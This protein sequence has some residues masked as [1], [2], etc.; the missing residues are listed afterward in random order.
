[1]SPEA[2]SQIGRAGSQRPAAA[3]WWEQR[4]AAI[5]LILLSAVP[6]L[7]PAIPPLVDLLGHMGRYRVELDLATS[8]W[9]HDYY[10]FRWS[11][12]GNLGADILVL[13]LS[14]LFGLELAVKLIVLAIPP[15]TVAGFLWV[16]REVHGRIPPT[17]LFAL[18]FAYSHPFMYGFVNFALSIALAFLAFGLWLRLARLG[19][20]KLRAILFVPISLIV[21]FTHTFGWGV[22]GLLC[23]S[24]EAVR[25]HD[26]GERWFRSGINAALHASVMALPLVFML[27]WRTSIHGART[28]HWFDFGLKWNFF[29]ASLRDRWWWF[30]VG[31]I[32]V[33]LLVMVESL[34]HRD[35]TFSRNL[36]F[37]ALVLSAGFILLPYLVFSSAYADMRMIPYVIAV[38]LLAIRFRGDTLRPRADVTAALGLLFFVV[39]IAGNT[40]SL[41]TAAADQ[42]GKL[43]ALDHVPMGARVLSLVHTGCGGQ[44]SLPRNTHLGALNIVRRHGFSNDQWVTEGLNL[45]SLRFDEARPFTSDPSQIVR[46]PRCVGKAYRSPAAAFRAIPPGKFDFLWLIDFPRRDLALAA[47]MPM[48]WRG[49]NAILYRL[50][51]AMPP[52]D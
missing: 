26:S 42:S 23:F 14:K 39:R 52:P 10:G 6:L 4:A 5:A 27:S 12:I 17:A 19:R 28:G 29:L 46:V 36:A 18:P 32:I 2:S 21:Y 49:H 11:P 25:Q 24:G 33:T 48:V 16:A 9:L 31:A 35:L 40:I 45:L 51:R 41:E 37:S 30:D 15:M 1:M 7:Y 50:P 34:R 20:L 47:G 44:W 8:P 38:L 43:E 3:P 22:L 13:P